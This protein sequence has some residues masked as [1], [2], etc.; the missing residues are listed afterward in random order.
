MI[1]SPTNLKNVKQSDSRERAARAAIIIA[2]Y[3]AANS[4]GASPKKLE[5]IVLK[6]HPEWI[7]L[8]EENAGK[9]S[10]Q[11]RLTN[12]IAWGKNALKDGGYTITIKG[13]ARGG[14]DI[15]KLSDKGKQTDFSKKEGITYEQHFVLTVEGKL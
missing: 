13:A 1:K 11:S 14:K 9:N 5:E 7:L 10:Y 4:L 3:L 15:L 8:H 6:H 2:E 12:D